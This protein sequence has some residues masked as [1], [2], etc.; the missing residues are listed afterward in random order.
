MFIYIEPVHS[1]TYFKVKTTILLEK[2]QQPNEEALGNGGRMNYLLTGSLIQ[3]NK[4]QEVQPPAL[5]SLG[6]K[7]KKR[8]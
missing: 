1:I 8:E 4:L 3:Q 7:G 2:T 6:V 5:T